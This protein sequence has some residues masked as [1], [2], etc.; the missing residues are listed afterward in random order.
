[1]ELSSSS[2]RQLRCQMGWSRSDLAHRLG[3]QSQEIGRWEEG[4]AAPD[5]SC[6]RLLESLFNQAEFAALEMAESPQIDAILENQKQ[7]SVDRD[8][9]Q[10]GA[11]N[12]GRVKSRIL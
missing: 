4:Q 9:L 10:N 1:M 2:I 5:E 12:I 7:S 11:L 8:Q 3:V 6:K